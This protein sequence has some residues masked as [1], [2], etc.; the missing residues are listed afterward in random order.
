MRKK[1]TEVSNL[2]EDVLF[3][4]TFLGFQYSVAC[5]H[6]LEQNSV[7]AGIYGRGVL[8]LMAARMQKKGKQ[9][10]EKPSTEYH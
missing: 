4:F 5:P 6:T 7:V 3:W 2:Q 9:T 10:E 1:K 8:Y